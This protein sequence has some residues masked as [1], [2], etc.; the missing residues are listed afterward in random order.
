MATVLRQVSFTKSE[1]FDLFFEPI[2]KDIQ[3]QENFR[4]M[5]NVVSKKKMGFVQKLEKI[6]QKRVGCGFT[7]KGKVGVYT[8][9]IEVD[10]FKVNIAQCFDEFKD[11]MFEDQLRKGNMQYDIN[12]TTI[13]NILIAKVRDAMDLD[14]NRLF[15]FG[16]KSSND[17]TYNIV[18]G[19]WS[20][21]I[22]EL[23]NNNQT[24][25]IN[26][27]SGAPLA[28]GDAIDLLEKMYD[29][30]AR[31][32]KGLAV[33]RKRFYVSQSVWDGYRKDLQNLGGGDAGRMQ[34]IDGVT[35]LKYE[36]IQLVPMLLWDE[37]MENDLGQPDSH[38]VLLSSP[39][40][41]VFATDL[42]SDLNTIEVFFDK[43]EEQ[44]YLKVNGKFGANYV[45]PQLMVAAY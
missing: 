11:T 36:G 31:P 26:S 6:I 28:P 10:S 18:N 3:A 42:L 8:R 14:Y 19:L 37:Y 17:V 1:T 12:G 15:W 32:L 4:V 16:D 40:N 35:M 7:P 33:N 2:W 24:P 39:D 5:P 9:E 41:L 45:H 23:V 29:A 38:L 30:Q 27:G 20:V 44:T 25:Y 34:T 43:L 22:E 21:Y 13:M